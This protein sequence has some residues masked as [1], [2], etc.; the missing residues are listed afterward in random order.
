MLS[1]YL[2]VAFFIF[3]GPHVFGKPDGD[4]EDERSDAVG[5][6]SAVKVDAVVE[7]YGYRHLIM[8]S[9]NIEEELTK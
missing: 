4:D 6:E 5:E 9:R 8:E 1:K 2:V 7:T 3:A